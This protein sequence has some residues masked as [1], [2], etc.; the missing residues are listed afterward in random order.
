M[1]AAKSNTLRRLVRVSLRT[2]TSRKRAEEI[3]RVCGRVLECGPLERTGTQWTFEMVNRP[4]IETA[5]VWLLLLINDVVMID[6][7]NAAGERQA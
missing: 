7:A 2:K 4:D 3:R 1:S 5:E 6:Y